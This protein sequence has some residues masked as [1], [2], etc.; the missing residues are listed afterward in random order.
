MLSAS[1]KS[2]GFAHKHECARQ[3]EDI[4]GHNI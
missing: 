1:N 4:Y 2:T 3:E